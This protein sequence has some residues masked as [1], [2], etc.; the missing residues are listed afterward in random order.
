MCRMCRSGISQAEPR[1]ERRLGPLAGPPAG[2]AVRGNDPARRAPSWPNAGTWSST[3]TGCCSNDS[4][5]GPAL[6]GQG[7]M[8]F[9]THPAKVTLLLLRRRKL[10]QPLRDAQLE[11]FVAQQEAVAARDAVSLL[12]QET[13]V[14]DQH[15]AFL[16]AL[17][18]AKNNQLAHLRGL[19]EAVHE[20]K[21]KAERKAYIAEQQLLSSGQAPASMQPGSSGS[22]SRK[23]R[24]PGPML[25]CAAAPA[26]S[27]FGRPEP[28]L[29]LRPGCA[30]RGEHLPEP[31]SGAAIPILLAGAVKTG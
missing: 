3:A 11:C 14:K 12:Q 16:S 8:P 31:T 4:L 1:R 28:A 22:G 2:P 24:V 18:D 25:G 19:Y 29:L 17:V 7:R 6:P 9:R 26:Q 23:C 21:L 5:P 20:G 13:R 27:C 10:K 15:I 30:L